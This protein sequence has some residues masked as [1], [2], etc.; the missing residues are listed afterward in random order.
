MVSTTYRTGSWMGIVRNGSVIALHGQTDPAIVSHLWEFLGHQ[1]TIHGVLNEVTEKFGTG[2]TGLPDFAI[3]V[4][5]DRLHAILRGDITLLA[6][7]GDAEDVVSGRDVTTWSERSLVLPNSF[8]L[9]MAE[10]GI[11]GEPLVLPIGEAVVAL[12]SLNMHLTGP[13]AFSTHDGGLVAS[14]PVEAAAEQAVDNDDAAEGALA[15]QKELEPD[16]GLELEPELDPV[17]G[18]GLDAQQEPL[19]DEHGGEEPVGEEQGSET[20]VAGG[21]AMAAEAANAEWTAQLAPVHA[22]DSV[23]PDLNRT[24]RPEQGEDLEQGEA[25]EREED[26]ELSALE[27]PAEV[28]PEEEAPGD[29]TPGDPTPDTSAVAAA[30]AADDGFTTNY[31]YLFG[32]TVAK[33]VEDAAVRLDEDG[34]P[35]EANTGHAMP[36]LPPQLPVARNGSE[37]SGSSGDAAQPGAQV[38]G[39][40]DDSTQ[41]SAAQ[42]DRSQA[43]GSPVGFAA[44]GAAAG[45]SS[46]MGSV[47]GARNPGPSSWQNQASAELAQG[48]ENAGLL[49]DSVPWRNGATAATPAAPTAPVA[50]TAEPHS[51]SDEPYDPDHDGHTVMR[52]DVTGAR[53]QP[54]TESLDSR[55]PSGPMVL[56]RLCPN[57]HANPPSRSLCSDCGIGINSEPREV[58]RPRLGT[59][60]ISSGEVIELDH[61]LI[62]GRQPSVSRVMGG[63]MPRLVRVTSGNDDISRSHVE[64]RLDGW[65]VLLVDLKAT[66]GTVLVREGQSPR[67]L[68]QGEEAI[69]LNGDIAELGDGVS[70]LF[71][72]LL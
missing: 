32:A 33:S 41:D 40:Q 7:T 59:M 55:P 29:Q 4:Q 13:S 48:T 1:P 34:Q 70:L 8:V 61:S 31:D 49:I 2:L 57:G 9:T 24:I 62:I 17:P 20:Q 69:L 37:D 11:T 19:E 30:E 47:P 38:A 63:A 18:H 5:S 67:R 44:A 53:P 35:V 21:F 10:P 51:P 6:Y 58:G 54:V 43:A 65:D 72:G 60:H 12:Q 50:P 22:P 25:R 42:G 39:A 27:A 14:A 36:P 45:G 56:A 28:A 23:E 16:P 3:V 71:D 52:S 64:V 15:L 68:S 46:A 66:N 26:G